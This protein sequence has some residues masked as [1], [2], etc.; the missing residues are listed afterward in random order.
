VP[1]VYFSS[2]QVFRSLSLSRN[3]GGGG[4]GDGDSFIYSCRSYPPTTRAY[5]VAAIFADQKRATEAGGARREKE[6]RSRP[7]AEIFSGVNSFFHRHFFVCLNGI[8]KLRE[9]PPWERKIGR[10]YQTLP[11]R[12]QQLLLSILHGYATLL[13]SGKIPLYYL[14]K[15]QI[16]VFR[17]SRFG[18]IKASA[19]VTARKCHP[20]GREIK[21]TVHQRNIARVNLS[22]WKNA[23]ATST[24][25]SNFYIL[26]SFFVT[27][28]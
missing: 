18:G 4:G 27:R 25:I 24:S 8:W 9:V 7:G 1:S 12:F 19:M 5:Q 10:D 14:V 26:F 23:F 21:V 16:V 6:L 13:G 2:P 28:N 11:S 15:F 17:D 20:E 3:G 22:R